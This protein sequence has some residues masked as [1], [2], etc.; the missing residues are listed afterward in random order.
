MNFCKFPTKRSIS[1]PLAIVAWNL[2]VFCV[3]LC[4]SAA[5]S[6]VDAIDQ[7]QPKMVK[8]YGAG[9][10][11]GL[12]AYQSGILISSEGHI[13]TAFSHVLDTDYV[14]AV[15]ADGRK[16]EAKL[17]GADPRLE[18]AVLKIDAA[19]TPCFD[20]GKAV[21]VEAGALVLT[22]SN[23]FGVAQGNEPAS[24]QKGTVSVVTRLEARRGAFETP[25]RG[26]IYVLDVTTN[27][28]GAAGGALVTR[29]GELAGM[30]GK[31]LRNASN[32][33]WLNYALPIAKLRQSVDEIRAGKFVAREPESGRKPQ[34]SLD[35]PSRGIVLI[36]DVLERTPPYV[37]HVRPGSAAE[38]AGLR[39]D[40]LILL[41]GDRLVPSCKAL[42][43]DLEYVD[44]ED[45]IKL[46]V[47]R[48]QELIEFSLP[49]AD[50]PKTLEKGQPQ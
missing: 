14:T 7:V 24:V 49:A 18:A 8:I 17:L 6:I 37:D 35:L 29:R 15:L 33:T 43:S 12:E 4:S 32:N 40:D 16:F 45:E 28:P 26:P 46:T 39:P 23:L 2:L 34:R 30:L 41:L 44:Y 9:G 22:F 19:G 10:L 27:N 13:L 20:L 1:F 47:L 5:A 25:Y 48:G 11:H 36:P 31:E 38:K 21:K 42:A 3:V 50:Q